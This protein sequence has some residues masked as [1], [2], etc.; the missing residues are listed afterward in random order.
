MARMIK[1]RLRRTPF[2][3][4]PIA[5]GVLI[6]GCG[7]SSSSSTTSVSAGGASTSASEAA[8]AAT[9]D[10]PDNQEFLRYKNPQAG[11]SI[12]YPE[13]W[14]QKGSANDVTFS[15]KGNSV[16]IAVTKGAAPTVCVGD[17]RAEEGGREGPDAASRDA[18]AGEASERPR[19]FTSST[20]S[21]G[22]RI[23]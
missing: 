16:Q 9:G 21:R 18:S 7:S 13:G 1:N 23:R 12:K 17:R 15:D 8:S 19:R 14:A 11:Y 22:R 3:L 4:I 5:A 2:L 20:T 6:A 10:I